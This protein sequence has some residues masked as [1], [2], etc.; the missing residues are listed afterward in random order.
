[1]SKARQLADLGNQVDDGAITGSSMVINGGMNVAQR[2]NRSPSGF[3][4]SFYAGPDRWLVNRSGTGT[5]GFS[6]VSST[7][8]GGTKAAQATF[9]AAAGETF[10]VTQRIEAANIAHLAGQPVTL[11][12]WVSGSNDAGSATLNASLSYAGSADNFASETVIGSPQSI[13]YTGTAQRITMSVTLPSDAANGVAIRIAGTKTTATGTFTLTFGGVCLNAGDSAIDFP[14]ESYGETLARCQRYFQAFNADSGSN[15]ILS[16]GIAETTSQVRGAVPLL[17]QMR[18][19]PSV[20][21]SNITDFRFYTTG[22]HNFTGGA[23]NG[24]SKKAMGIFASTSASMTAGHA[25]QVLWANATGYLH[26]D[27]EL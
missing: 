9:L 17:V 19:V 3:T 25:G 11:S 27:A 24:L 15:T 14:H 8:F 2:G 20:S 12:F 7:D 26:A 18:A 13:V 6:Q 23:I 16:N 21:V 5:T 1:M 10:I 4:G 22:Q